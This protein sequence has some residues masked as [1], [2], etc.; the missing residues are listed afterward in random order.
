M[1]FRLLLA[2]M[3]FAGTWT[4]S[5]SAVYSQPAPAQG[6]PAQGPEITIRQVSGE[7]FTLDIIDNSST[8]SQALAIN[9]SGQMIGIREVANANQTVFSQ[10][11]FFLDG[12]QTT[13]LPSLKGFTNIEA[14][15]LSDNGMV[16]GYASRPMGHPQGSLT[17]IVWDSKTGE[18]TR[19]MPAPGDIASQAQD[20]SADGQRVSGYTS[21][22]EPPRLRP[23]VWTWD[24][25]NNNWEATALEVLQDFN[26]Y[27]MTSGVVISPDGTRVATCITVAVS[28]GGA[29]DSSLF[30]WEWSGASWTRRLVSDEQMMVRD[31]NNQGEI[32][33]TY[34]TTHGPD[35]C[36]IDVDGKLTRIGTFAGDV[37][38]EARGINA[39]GTVVG[40]SDDPHGPDGGPQ[41]FVWSAGKSRAL[42]L[43][44]GTLFSSAFGINDRGQIA[45]LMDMVLEPPQPA[46]AAANGSPAK[47]ETAVK[48]LAFRWTPQP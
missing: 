23:C 40:F 25:Q 7:G 11:Y 27:T 16:V 18:L 8:F 33:A 45:G 47:A 32:A 38:G 42:K 30:M 9:A 17:A 26:P 48:T 12:E 4:L 22:S 3:G 43:P 6:Q 41:A 34:T 37:S 15:A 21:G 24:A 20:I 29:Y 31:M 19:L 2:F 46:R 10:E 36:F 13:K 44:A 5:C 28:A 1:F 35:P 39:S 14:A